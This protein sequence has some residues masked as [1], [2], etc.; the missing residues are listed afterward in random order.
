MKLYFAPLEG[1]TTYIY[2]NTHRE[3]FGGCDSYYAPF[4]TPSEN[5]RITRKSLRDILPDNNS[6]TPVVP[7]I[8]AN[9]T[10][11]FLNFTEKIK[12]IGYDEI[13]LNC[14]CPS[15]TVVKKSRGAGILKDA[16]ALDEFLAGIFN[17][18]ELKIS[19]KTRIGFS[20]GEEMERLLE[21]Y[22]K[23]PIPQLTIHPRTRADFY[24]GIPDMETFEKA[25]RSSKNKVCY[26]GNVFSV[27]DYKGIEETYPD[28]E[29]IMLGRGAVANPAIFREIRGGEKLSTAELVEF[30][31]I[32]C[33]NYR[34][35]LQSDVYTLNKLKEIWLYIM[36][37]FPNEKK[38]LK[39]MRKTN[40]LSEFMFTVKNLPELN[41]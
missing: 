26:N 30:T 17:K 31:E 21:I 40:N 11:V 5:E 34:F 35:L 29:G 16:V 8:I 23:Y 22:N 37:N 25:Y 36:W 7:Q 39:I 28:L 41:T 20:S 19:V 15:G 3:M 13:N 10:E 2:R 12:K 9:N 32:L 14:G 6:E 4:I 33:E 27:D 38:S 24:N 1:I 18:C